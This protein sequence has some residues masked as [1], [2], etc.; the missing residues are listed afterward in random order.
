MQHGINKSKRDDP[1]MNKPTICVDFDGVLNTYKGWNGTDNLYQ[2]RNGVHEF[3]CKLNKEYQ[4]I[5]FTTRNEGRVWRW[6][7]EYGLTDYIED[8]T[9]HKIGAIAYIDDRGIRFNGD[10]NETLKELKNFQTHW[11]KEEAKKQ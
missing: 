8:V 9:S 11:E 6:L 10:Y 4:V 7:F 2:P 1:Q 5:I 3:L